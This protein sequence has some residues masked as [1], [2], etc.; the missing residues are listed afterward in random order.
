MQSIELQTSAWYGDQSVSLEFP[1]QWEVQ[2]TGDQALSALSDSAIRQSILLPIASPPLSELAAQRKRAVILIDDLTRPT[3]TAQLLPIIIDQLAKA[4]LQPDQISILVAGGTHTP[5]SEHE[6]QQKVG[7]HLP[8]GLKF[9]AHDSHTPMSYL[10][11]MESGTPLYINPVVLESDLRIGLGCIYP[12]P[13]AGFS[14]GAKILVPGAA[15]TE[16]IR[17]MHDHLQGAGQRGG[18]LDSEFRIEV[19]KIASKIG[20]DFIVNVTLNQDRSICA[21]FSGDKFQAFERGV[22]FARQTYTVDILDD[23]DI[24]IADMYPFD[25]DLQF[26]YD[27]GLWPLD[28]AKEDSTKV[29]LASC[30]AGVGSHPLFPVQNSFWVRLI[31]RLRYF[32]LRDLKTFGSRLKAAKRIVS[33]KSLQVNLVSSGL[34][35]D[36]FRTVFPSGE[37][38]RDW[39]S[40]LTRFENKY[41]SRPVSVVI[42]RCA[43]LMLPNSIDPS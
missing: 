3:P 4:G 16:T 31:R 40:A 33:R 2:V 14:G 27:R 43:P 42:Y 7:K 6:I 21:I 1:D 30:P 11:T 24:T 9:I 15:G 38:F 5:A 34:S 17:Y 41:S 39:P 22:D 19:N 10:G 23:A 28:F 8:S 18:N 37:L 29:I 35:E 20:L 25:A 12:H 26:S 13:A 36:Q 32:Q